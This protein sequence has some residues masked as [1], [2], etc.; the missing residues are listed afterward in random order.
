MVVPIKE[1]WDMQKKYVVRLTD[2]EREI[3]SK[4]LKHGRVSAQKVRRA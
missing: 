2:A 3:L 4:L 1:G